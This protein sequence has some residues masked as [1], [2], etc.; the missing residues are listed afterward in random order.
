[1]GIH[2]TGCASLDIPKNWNE[3]WDV[4]RATLQVLQE[5]GL[6]PRHA[7]LALRDSDVRVDAKSSVDINISSVA[8]LRPRLGTNHIPTQLEREKLKR[9]AATAAKEISRAFTRV[10]E[11]RR[12]LAEAEASYSAATALLEPYL[13]LLS[14][15]RTLPPEI[16]QEIFIAGMPTRHDVIMHPSQ[17][18][19]ILGQVCAAWRALSRAT[20][21]LWASVHVAL[22]VGETS[23]ALAARCDLLRRWLARS[24]DVVPLQI[25]LFVPVGLPLNVTVKSLVD[26][27]VPYSRRW[28]SLTLVPATRSELDPV[29]KLDR[30]DVP[31]LESIEVAD[32]AYQSREPPAWRRFIE[33]PRTLRR[34]ALNYFNAATPLPNCAWSCITSLSLG[35]Q[36]EFFGLTEPQLLQLLL[37]CQSLE[38][39]RLTLPISPTIPWTPTAGPPLAAA[40]ASPPQ[41]LTLSRLKTFTIAAD[42]LP[43]ATFNLA[44]ILDALVLPAL[45]LLEVAAILY[46]I[47]E[48]SPVAAISD[49]ILATDNLLFRSSC[50]LR[51]L[52]VHFGAGDA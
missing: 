29:W 9:F 19:L 49:P 21:V 31:M 12:H 16:L 28:R 42:V 34:V 7:I 17:I 2:C 25:S 48:F 5:R 52:S 10:Q 43:D 46:H 22:C 11:I 47:Y 36:Q 15:I 40:A 35:S 18:P 41:T 1:M 4:F 37:Q 3:S 8:H 44:R 23:S 30:E 50:D 26:I 27:I 13:A 33:L 20:P 32:H 45:Q 39:C 24:G 14:P 38:D 51:A 6:D